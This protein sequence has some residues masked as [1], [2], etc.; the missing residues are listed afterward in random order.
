VRMCEVMVLIVDLAEALGVTKI[1]KMPGC[2]ELA[3]D[4]LWWFA[5]NG[6]TEPTECSH[7]ASVPPMSA[8]LEYNGWPAGICDA[9]GGI[10]AAGAAANESTLVDALKRR[11]EAEKSRMTQ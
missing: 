5:V 1:N 3:V 6:H 8:Y 10:V 9:G 7:G 4:D 11:I 2:W